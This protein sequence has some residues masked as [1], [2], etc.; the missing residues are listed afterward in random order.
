MDDKSYIL[1]RANVVTQAASDVVVTVFNSTPSLFRP[2]ALAA[3]RASVE[4]VVATM[5]DE[6]R[7]CYAKTLELITFTTAKISKG[8]SKL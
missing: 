2:V 7:E 1:H 5:D 6:S 8:G 4:S 3:L